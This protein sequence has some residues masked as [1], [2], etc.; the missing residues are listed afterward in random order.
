[1]DLVESALV[2]VEHEEFTRRESV[3]LFAEFA[4]DASTGTRDQ[5]PSTGQVPGDLV[6]VR[7]HLVSSHQVGRIKVPNV[8]DRDTSTDQ[9]VDDGEDLDLQRRRGR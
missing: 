6:D 2:P 8:A 9:V 4:P 1:M 7:L 3:D 5:N